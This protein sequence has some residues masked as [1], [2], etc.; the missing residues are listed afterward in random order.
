MK[1]NKLF[2]VVL[3]GIFLF[4]LV[5]SYSGGYVYSNPTL[6][7]STGLFTSYSS[8]FGTSNYDPTYFDNSMCE[9]GQDFLIELCLQN[10][11]LL[12]L[13]VIF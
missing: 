2:L 9:E 12:L 6:S 1:I 5:S 3:V 8:T 7:S 4:G 10:V 13:E 11:V